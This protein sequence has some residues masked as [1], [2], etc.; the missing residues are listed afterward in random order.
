MAMEKPIE[1][2]CIKAQALADNFDEIDSKFEELFYSDEAKVVETNIASYETGGKTVLQSDNFKKIEEKNEE[3]I[4][5]LQ[6]KGVK[7]YLNGR[8]LK[9][10]NPDDMS[11]PV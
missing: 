8:T 4:E 7:V 11:V 5:Q 2:L 6:G 3:V 10:V 9:F 1:D